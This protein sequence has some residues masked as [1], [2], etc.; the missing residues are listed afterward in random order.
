MR[1][2]PTVLILF[3]LLCGGSRL[4]AQPLEFPKT[5][6]EIVRG[7]QPQSPPS[8]PRTRGL[9]GQTRGIAKVSDS[10]PKVA[11]LILFDYNSAAIRPESLPLL[12]EFGKALQGGLSSATILVV[13]HTDDAGDAVYNERLSLRRAGAVKDCLVSRHGIDPSRIQ[14]GGMG[15]AQPVGDNG[16][17]Q[18]RAMN[19][20]VEFERIGSP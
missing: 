1:L 10:S 11:A 16:T 8:Q 20:R 7:L 3:A 12:D 17:E 14:V 9:A 15:E 18:G 6:E 19:R 5:E 4:H 13:G 2:M